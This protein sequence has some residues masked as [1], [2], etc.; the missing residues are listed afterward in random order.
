MLACVEGSYV[1]FCLLNL[2]T[3]RLSA[4][5]VATLLPD[6]LPELQP[7]IITQLQLMP[8]DLT[9]QVESE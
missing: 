6:Q 2:Q 1:F 8:I 5:A 3:M 9:K 7:S 4:T